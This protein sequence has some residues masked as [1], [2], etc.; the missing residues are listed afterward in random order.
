M[1]ITV[2]NRAKKVKTK[3]KKIIFKK[4]LIYNSTDRVKDEARGFLYFDSKNNKWV[5]CGIFQKKLSAIS[6]IKK[7]ENLVLLL[8]SPHKDEYDIYG[9][10]LR[11]ANGIT[12]TN[13]NNLFAKQIN[14]NNLII[15]TLQNNIAYRVWIVNA[16]QYQTSGYNQLHN[17]RMY[18]QSWRIVRNNVFKALWNNEAIFNLQADLVYRLN[19][20]APSIIINCV[21]GGKNKNGLRMLVE[22]GLQNHNLISSALYYHPSYW[23]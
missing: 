9:N 5:F 20:I 12:G 1:Q 18:N 11:P 8:E 15:N 7:I 16:I 22:N 21:T 19:Q 3:S 6:Y 14:N 2:G 13:I 10:P 23:K 17:I 4:N